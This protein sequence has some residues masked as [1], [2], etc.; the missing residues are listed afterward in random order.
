MQHVY[1]QYTHPSLLVLHSVYCRGMLHWQQD[2]CSTKLWGS[3]TGGERKLH[4]TEQHGGAVFERSTVHWRRTCHSRQ[5]NTLQAQAKR[6]NPSP[7]YTWLAH[8]KGHHS[9]GSQT[10]NDVT[11]RSG[12]I[13]GWKTTKEKHESINK[14]S[15]NLSAL[16]LWYEVNITRVK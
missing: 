11:T 14:T 6:A 3:R 4:E 15:K 7:G 1:G 13:S 9:H 5:W 12:R 16:K 10:C 2:I 8:T